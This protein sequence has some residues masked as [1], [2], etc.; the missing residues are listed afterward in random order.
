MNRNIQH[1]FASLEYTLVNQIKFIEE[2]DKLFL[3]PQFASGIIRFLAAFSISVG[4]VF[5]NPPYTKGFFGAIVFGTFA[6]FLLLTILPFIIGS[7]V[8]YFAQNKERPGRVRLMVLFSDFSV[9]IYLLFCPIAVI[10]GEVG[11]FGVGAYIL[12]L[13]ILTIFYLLNLTRGAKYIYELKDKDSMRIVFLSF[14]IVSVVPLV[15]GIFFTSSI[16]SIIG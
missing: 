2:I 4:S 14:V 1:F 8:D 13:L 5:L 9:L 11:I 15:F 10:L 3:K 6:D 12:L 16:F 7:L